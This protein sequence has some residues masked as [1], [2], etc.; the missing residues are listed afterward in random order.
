MP[1]HAIDHSY[2]Q[3]F[4]ST[5]QREFQLVVDLI[6]ISTTVVGIETI[7]T[8]AIGESGEQQFYISSDGLDQ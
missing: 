3:Q 1:D 2:S 6:A 5:H 8:I 7:S 4:G